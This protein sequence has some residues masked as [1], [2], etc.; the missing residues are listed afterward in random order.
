MKI[1]SKKEEEIGSLMK[2]LDSD[3]KALKSE[4]VRV[5]REKTEL[6]EKLQKFL[7]WKELAES[8]LNSQQ[9]HIFQEFDYIEN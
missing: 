6:E 1:I 7:E 4:D 2:D 8:E 5:W 9:D 3:R